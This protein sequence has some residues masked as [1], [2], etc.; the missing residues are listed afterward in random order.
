MMQGRSAVLSSKYD[1][2]LVPNFTNIQLVSLDSHRQMIHYIN[3]MCKDLVC[4][5]LKGWE[6]EKLLFN[7]H[8]LNCDIS[9]NNKY[10]STLFRT[11]ID[12]T[13][14]QG[15]AL[16]QYSRTRFPP[17]ECFEDAC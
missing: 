14:M 15:K 10:R 11:P 3:N 12:D 13:N 9:V 7:L 6:S 2:N 5:K 17:N 4:F 1:I 16:T 8:F